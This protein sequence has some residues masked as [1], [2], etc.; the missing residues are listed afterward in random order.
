MLA[1]MGKTVLRPGGVELTRAMLRS[2]DIG[3]A[4]DVVELAPGLGATAERTLRRVPRS[5]VGVDRDADVVADLQNRLAGVGRRFIHGDAA[6]TGLPDACASVAYAEAL[7]SMQSRATKEAIV[8]ELSRLVKSGGRVGIHELAFRNELTDEHM[9]QFERQLSEA[10][11]H[12]VLPIRTSEWSAL[13]EANGLQVET[14][15]QVPMAMLE[16]GRIVQ[17]EGLRRSVRF[18]TGVL[19]NAQ[20][21]KR[22]SGMRTTFRGQRG[23]L[24]GIMIVARKR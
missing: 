5:Y 14:F 22:I 8:T 18:F 2:L 13:L 3:A 9:A 6:A 15:Q 24:T 20:A 16:L 4:D 10:V 17:D 21:R 12:P 11:R 19:L 1:S 7:L 23:D